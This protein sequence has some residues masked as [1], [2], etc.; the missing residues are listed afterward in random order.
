MM[1]AVG[2]ILQMFFEIFFVHG[3]S[4]CTQLADER[5]RTAYNR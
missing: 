1:V 5:Q 3:L 4:A 2:Q